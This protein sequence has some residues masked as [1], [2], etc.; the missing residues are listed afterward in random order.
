MMKRTLW[1]LIAVLLVLQGCAAPAPETA[2]EE[3]P[4]EE[5]AYDPM[6]LRVGTIKGPSGLGMVKL[7]S[8]DPVYGENVGTNYEI[9]ASPD[10]LVAKVLKDEIDIAVLPTNVA[11][12]LYNKG[13]DYQLIG[14]NTWGVLYLVENQAGVSTWDDLKGRE[15]TLF[16]KGSSPDVVFRYLLAENG[17]TEEDVDIEY[18]ASHIELSQMMIAGK[19]TL[20]LLPEPMVTMVQMKNPDLSIAMNLQDA[21]QEAADMAFP[22]GCLVARKGLIEERPEV[23]EAFLTAYDEASVWVNDHGEEAGALAESYELGMTAP[24][25]QKAIPRCN[26]RLGKSYDVMETVD[27]YLTV[28]YEFSPQEVG[29]KV[30]DEGFY[31]S[32]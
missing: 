31:Y 9:A 15:V 28:L 5:T 25:A 21:W 8:D 6:T 27:K 3:A 14:V 22:Q 7:M 12:M 32:K 18:M 1:I 13:V 4:Q 29:G 30:P 16:S 26:I 10:L 23:V 24:M 17:L 2:P 19:K 20:G 11:A